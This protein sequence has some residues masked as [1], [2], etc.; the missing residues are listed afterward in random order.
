[1]QEGFLDSVECG[2]KGISREWDN[3]WGVDRGHRKRQMG[4]G[5]T[6][7]CARLVTGWCLSASGDLDLVWWG[8]M[9]KRL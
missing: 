7:R 3:Y 8:Y 1:M 4:E 6:W 2:R 9:W 5:R